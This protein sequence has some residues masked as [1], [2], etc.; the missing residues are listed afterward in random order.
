MKTF[1]NICWTAED[2]CAATGC[3]PGEFEITSRIYGHLDGN[4]HD[5]AFRNMPKLIETKLNASLTSIYNNCCTHDVV[6]TTDGLNTK[7]GKNDLED[8]IKDV[9]FNDPATIVLWKDGTKTV[10]KAQEGCEFDPYVGLAMAFSKKMFGNKGSYFNVFKKYCEPYEDED[11]K[12]KEF[13][14]V[15]KGIYNEIASKFH[16]PL[17]MLTGA[18]IDGEPKPKDDK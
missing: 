9:I 10:V 14:S 3:Y 1:D 5:I 7:Y 12:K 18:D 15:L 8:M 17:S 4:I 16:I 2:V 13:E 6:M 11:K